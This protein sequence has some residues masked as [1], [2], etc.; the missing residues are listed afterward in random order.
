MRRATLCDLMVCVLLLTGGAM[1]GEQT[2]VLQDVRATTKSGTCRV[3]F[4]FAGDVRFSSEQGNGFVRLVFPDTRPA[5]A[6]T[7]ARR[8]FA[9]GP[10]ER[11]AFSRAADGSLVATLALSG[12]SSYRC[13]SPSGG[14]ELYVDVHGSAAVRTPPPQAQVRKPVAS[15]ARTGAASVPAAAAT[16]G[17]IKAAVTPSRTAPNAG[18]SLAHVPRVPEAGAHAP[19]ETQSLIDIPA[20]ARRQMEPESQA[21][22][23][24]RAT[25]PAPAP[26]AGF[27]I[28]IALLMSMSISLVSTVTGFGVWYLLRRRAARRHRSPFVFAEAAATSGSRPMHDTALADEESEARRE[29]LLKQMLGR[30]MLEDDQEED[31]ERET[32]LQLA[33]TFKRGSEEITLTKRFH[34][35]ATPVLTSDRMDNVLS[36]ATTPTQRLHA[37]RKLGV[38]RGEFDLAL[39]LKSMVQDKKEAHV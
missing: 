33:R 25:K 13:V 22:T 39:K 4:T 34:D 11:I 26:A 19:A 24:V 23:P 10:V 3:T 21:S 9:N 5:S 17:A 7:I 29:A 18:I 6:G 30:D 2:S 36:H 14:R 1:A 28:G 37:A 32:S 35:Q 31:G 20:L 38:G 16:K 27:P 8:N 15:P 12:G